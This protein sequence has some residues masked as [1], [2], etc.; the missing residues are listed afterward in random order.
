[1]WHAELQ[2]CAS[3]SSAAS[4]GSFVSTITSDWEVAKVGGL[5]DLFLFIT[6]PEV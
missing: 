4:P 2:Q 1:M 5:S 6:Q 3:C